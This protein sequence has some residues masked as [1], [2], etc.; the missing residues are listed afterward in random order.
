MAKAKLNSITTTGPF[1]RMRREDVTEIFWHAMAVRDN[2]LNS[3]QRRA[4]AAKVYEAAADSM[5][6]QNDPTK[7]VSVPPA[8]FSIRN[9]FSDMVSQL[10]DRLPEQVFEEYPGD[11]QLAKT[12][13]NSADDQ[14]LCTDA[15]L[16][17]LDVL[18]SFIED[19]EEYGREAQGLTLVKGG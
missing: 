18:Q 6:F 3:A 8:E 7:P 5:A 10:L 12:V 11:V 1:S 17:A 2:Q 16:F 13:A 15:R 4:D 9:F 14:R 19:L